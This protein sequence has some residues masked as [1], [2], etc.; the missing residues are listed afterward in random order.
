M[1]F[2]DNTKPVSLYIHIPFCTTKCAYCAFYSLE[3]KAV[4][5]EEKELFYKTILNQLDELVEDLKR[6]FYTIFIGGGNPG[7][8]GFDKLYELL[9]TACRYGKAVEC[10][11]EINPEFLNDDII[12]LFEYLTRVSVGIQSMS[13]EH[14]KTLGRNANRNTNIKALELLNK[15]K[16]KYGITF[17]ADIMTNIPTESIEDAINDIKAVSDYNP[18]HISLYSLTFEEG[19]K[20]IENCVPMDEEEQRSML[21]S[22]WNTLQELGYKQYEIS[23]FAKDGHECLHNKVYWELGQYIGLGPTAES[24]VGYENIISSREADSLSEYLKNPGFNSIKLTKDEAE[25]EY[26][27]TTLRTVYGIDKQEYYSRFHSNFDEKYRTFIQ[28]IDEMLYEDNKE[29]FS[30]T[31]EGFLLLDNVILSLAMAI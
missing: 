4:M 26:L 2:I 23:N 15:Y 29:K 12:P 14:L 3:E 13:S 18:D 24:S 1:E 30:L 8:L 20:L 11:T 9:K 17:N 27:L 28:E 16:N 7:M 10:T 22:C 21:I 19:T 25:E 31:R 5:A 6:P